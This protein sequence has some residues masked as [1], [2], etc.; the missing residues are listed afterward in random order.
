MTITD[1]NEAAVEA[2]R[3]G[4]PDGALRDVLLEHVAE[5]NIRYVTGRA[6]LAAAES[7]GEY[8][9]EA[10]CRECG[11]C[12]RSACLALAVAMAAGWEIPEHTWEAS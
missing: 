9:V 5:H 11:D 6:E 8:D 10:L 12:D 3:G 2:I 7:D 4:V 1:P